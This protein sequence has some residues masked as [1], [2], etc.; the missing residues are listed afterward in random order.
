MQSL[1]GLS[2]FTRREIQRRLRQQG[3]VVD[4]TRIL[5]GDLDLKLWQLLAILGV[6]EV[7]PM[8]FFQLVF[9]AAPEPRS[10]LLDLLEKALELDSP[11][12]PVLPGV[13]RSDAAA[14]PRPRP[15]PAGPPRGDSVRSRL[16]QLMGEL[17]KLIEEAET[18]K[19]G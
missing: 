13:P 19:G 4:V 7:Q 9:P 10:P 6:I 8:D 3:E 15:A 14:R 2:G 1:V 11:A 17:E 5:R 12:T 18:P 16:S